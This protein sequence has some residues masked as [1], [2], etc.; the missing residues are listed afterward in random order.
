MRGT[1]V[2]FQVRLVRVESLDPQT[3]VMQRRV[4]REVGTAPVPQFVPQFGYASLFPL[5]LRLIPTVSATSCT[6]ACLGSRPT[7]ESQSHFASKA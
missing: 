6:A 3:G 2:A 7:L 4:E 5:L 1:P